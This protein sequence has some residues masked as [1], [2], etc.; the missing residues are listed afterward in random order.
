MK[1]SGQTGDE[2]T[3][4]P[5]PPT[6]RVNKTLDIKQDQRKSGLSHQLWDHAAFSKGLVV[7][8]SLLPRREKTFDIMCILSSE[9]LVGWSIKVCRLWSQT[10][11][12]KILAP[13]LL[14]GWPWTSY[15]AFFCALVTEPVKKRKARR[16]TPTETHLPGSN[17]QEERRWPPTEGSHWLSTHQHQSL[18]DNNNCARYVF[19]SFSLSS[20]LLLCLF[21]RCENGGSETV[22]VLLKAIQ[23]QELEI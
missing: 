14:A 10:G 21:H 8:A 9:E 20:S 2:W 17:R 6:S 15:L 22:S 18:H 4:S 3:L 1:T 12:V 5:K 16:V 23:Q 11:W 7:S 19:L 13:H